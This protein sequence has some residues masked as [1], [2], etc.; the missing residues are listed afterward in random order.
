MLTGAE[1]ITLIEEMQYY[2]LEA[3]PFLRLHSHPLALGQ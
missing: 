3:L 2:P 1:G